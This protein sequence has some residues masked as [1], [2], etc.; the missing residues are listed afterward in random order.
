MIFLILATMETG[1]AANEESIYLLMSIITMFYFVCAVSSMTF[2]QSNPHEFVLSI[3]RWTEGYY[4]MESWY[5]Y[6]YAS[7]FRCGNYLYLV[8]VWTIA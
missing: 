8:T 6:N 1:L 5:E 4:I 7:N 3:C 2:S